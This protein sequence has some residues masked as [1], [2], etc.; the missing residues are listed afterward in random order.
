[1]IQKQLVNNEEQRIYVK[2][3]HNGHIIKL[4][5]QHNKTMI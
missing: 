2:S 5:K 4:N 3:V 1:M